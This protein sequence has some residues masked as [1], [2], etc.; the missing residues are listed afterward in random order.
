MNQYV[1]GLKLRI[2]VI[3]DIQT[4]WMIRGSSPEGG[5]ETF[6]FPKSSGRLFHWVPVF[7]SGAKAA[8]M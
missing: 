6:I 1:V 7:F 5:K 2:S 8:A 4:S 3:V